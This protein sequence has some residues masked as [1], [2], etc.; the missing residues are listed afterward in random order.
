MTLSLIDLGYLIGMKSRGYS[1]S[2][3]KKKLSEKGTTISCRQINRLYADWI[4]KKDNK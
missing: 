4:T 1:A 2:C 3:V